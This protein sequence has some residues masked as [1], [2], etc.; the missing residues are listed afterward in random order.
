LLILFS[1]GCSDGAGSD[2]SDSRVPLRVNDEQ[3]TLLYGHSDGNEAVFVL[4][5]LVVGQGGT[6]G[7]VEDGGGFVEGD[8]L[9][10]EVGSGFGRVELEAWHGISLWTEPRLKM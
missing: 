1:L 8:S 6:K 5:V 9:L 10:F 4:G 3:E 2:E 7:I